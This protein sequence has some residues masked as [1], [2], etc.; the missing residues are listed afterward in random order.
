MV[1]KVNAVE[2][3]E[4]MGKGTVIADFSATWCGP[5]RMLS[6]VMEELSEEKKDITFI[7]IDCDECPDIAGRYNIMSIPAVLLFKDGQK[8]AETVG[9]RSYEEMDEW[10]NGAL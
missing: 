3:D 1:K 9:F 2:F 7:N 10:I 8:V 5:C 4:L 6:P